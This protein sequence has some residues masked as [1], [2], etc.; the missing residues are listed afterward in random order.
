VRFR[1]REDEG[2]CPLELYNQ[3]HVSKLMLLVVTDSTGGCLVGQAP[4]CYISQLLIVHR[5]LNP[6]R[7]ITTAFV[8]MSRWVDDVMF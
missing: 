7:L 8:S 3:I 6:S 1:L 2:H 5:E 4:S